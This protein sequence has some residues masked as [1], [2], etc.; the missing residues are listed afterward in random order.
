MDEKWRLIQILWLQDS[1]HFGWKYQIVGNVLL[2]I[3][4][5]LEHPLVS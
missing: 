3:Q 4:K 1:S 5:G 2:A